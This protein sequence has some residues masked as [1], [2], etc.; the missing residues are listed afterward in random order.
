MSLSFKIH[1][2]GLSIKGKYLDFNLYLEIWSLDDFY[3]DFFP[4]HLDEF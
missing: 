3:I 4:P 1:L 2:C